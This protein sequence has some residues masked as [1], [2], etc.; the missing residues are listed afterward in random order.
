M[1]RTHIFASIVLVTICGCSGDSKPMSY[2]KDVTS[3]CSL[4]SADRIKIYDIKQTNGVKKVV[5][6]REV[7][8]LEFEANIEFLDDTWWAK[9]RFSTLRVDQ[10][11]MPSEVKNVYDGM[12][13]ILK[14]DKR[15]VSGSYRY[16]MTD[17]G[18]RPLD[19]FNQKE[20]VINREDNSI[21]P[22]RCLFFVEGIVVRLF[23]NKDMVY[24]TELYKAK[25]SSVKNTGASEE[26]QN[27][28]ARFK[29]LD[30]SS[31]NIDNV[32]GFIET[33]EK[34]LRSA[35]QQSVPDNQLDAKKF[36]R[37]IANNKEYDSIN[38]VNIGLANMTL[39]LKDLRSGNKESRVLDGINKLYKPALKPQP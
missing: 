35:T 9:D 3:L 20:K 28:L 14:G 13:L 31:S 10:L 22:Y 33:V 25:D 19:E 17:N 8:D 32:C 29:T 6:G 34:D 36:K 38:M 12:P 5:D 2:V 39:S 21:S 15:R 11:S 27:L 7:Y 16:E 30:P 26:A 1:I 37:Y 23:S 4:Q 24:Y 18:W